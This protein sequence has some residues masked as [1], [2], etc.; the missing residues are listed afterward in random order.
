MGGTYPAYDVAHTKRT[1]P[2]WSALKLKEDQLRAVDASTPAGIIVCDGGCALLQRQGPTHDAYS[3]SDIIQEFLA[4][5]PHISFIWVMAIDIS[6]PLSGPHRFSYRPEL[7][8]SKSFGR[9]RAGRL[10]ATIDHVVQQMPALTLDPMNAFRQTRE[11]G[12]GVG[13]RGGYEMGRRSVKISS[14]ALALMSPVKV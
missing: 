1:N 10:W 2:L 6:N 9:A 5:F 8:Y 11:P 4:E 12:Y 3:T 7:Y 14:R 13:H